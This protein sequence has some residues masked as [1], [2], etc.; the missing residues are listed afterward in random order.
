MKNIELTIDEYDTL[1]EAIN[2]YIITCDEKIEEAK[3]DQNRQNYWVNEK[4]LANELN[5]KVIAIE[6]ENT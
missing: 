5:K 2:N 4:E 1:Y 3:N 6:D